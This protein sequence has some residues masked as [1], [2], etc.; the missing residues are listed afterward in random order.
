ML[1]VFDRIWYQLPDPVH[2]LLEEI[3]SIALTIYFE[4]KW[5][6]NLLEL[7]MVAS[8]ANEA[9]NVTKDISRGLKILLNDLSPMVFTHHFKTLAFLG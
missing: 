8:L 5:L 3:W 6:Q 7:I 1:F 2:H 4:V 9:R